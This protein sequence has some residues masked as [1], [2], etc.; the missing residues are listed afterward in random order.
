MT[1][2]ILLFISAIFIDNIRS[3]QFPDI[4]PLTD[5]SKK[6]KAAIVISGAI[7]FVLALAII[8]NHTVQELVLNPLHLEFLQITSFIMII[9]ILARGTGIF[10]KRMLPKLFYTSEISFQ[11]LFVDS[12]L[13]GVA[14]LVT[15]K[16][17]TLTGSIAYAIFMSVGFGLALAVFAGITEQLNMI[18]LPRA[19]EGL[20]SVLLTAGLLAMAFMGFAGIVK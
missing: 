1:A 8:V 9:A 18:K 6:I 12:A 5:K 7:A 2:F 17:L 14:L 10:L 16:N 15:E 3:A 13:L 11:T 4:H 20:P 19:M